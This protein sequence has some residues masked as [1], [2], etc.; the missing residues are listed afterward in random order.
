MLVL[1]IWA[2]YS[3]VLKNLYNS[4]AFKQ[5]RV[6]DVERNPH[7]LYITGTE[8]VWCVLVHVCLVLE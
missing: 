5:H 7:F 2:S 3:A 4:I 6:T 8:L 1:D